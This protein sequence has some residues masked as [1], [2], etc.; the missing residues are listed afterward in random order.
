[1]LQVEDDNILEV[2]GVLSIRVNNWGP[3]HCTKMQLSGCLEY[4]INRDYISKS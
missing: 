3:T 4:Y 1:L 2:V